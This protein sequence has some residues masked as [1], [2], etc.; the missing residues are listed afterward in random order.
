MKNNM[1]T[2]S[3]QLMKSLNRS[4]ILNII[5]E[6]GPISRA[7]IAKLTKLTPPTVGNLVKELM[8]SEM[9]IETVLGESS[10]GRKPTMLT[11]NS[12]AFH[13]I[14]LDIGSHHL[15]VI[16]TNMEGMLI[17]KEMYPMP[18]VVSN[19]SL[20]DLLKKAIS[21][22]KTEAEITV[23][24]II[25]IGVGMH[26]IVD[27]ENGISVFAPN[28]NLKNIEI[29]KQ[30]EQ[31]FNMLV[32]VD[33]DARAMS[34][35]ELWFGN[36]TGVDSLVC[37]NVGRG[38]GAGIIIDGKLFRG[39]D[40]IGGEIGHMTID[41]NGP[42]CSCGNNG[43][44]QAFASGPAIAAT[45]QKAASVQESKLATFELTE[46]D[47]EAVYQAAVE[48]DQ[49]SQHILRQAGV[50]LGVGITN[51]IHMVNPERII[52]GGGVSNAKEFLLPAINETIAQ[53]GLTGS[54]QKT[55]ILISKFGEDATAIGAIALILREVFM[56]GENG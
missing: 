25:G 13:V 3:F 17:K 23:D 55:E 10:G 18:E 29:K 34:L 5:R 19:E 11:L 43:C 39:H 24:R 12:N 54:V 38:V 37:I 21:A 28:L 15:K 51:L 45:A 6:K 42:K 4:V 46:I 56:T 33:N 27:V 50:Y 31:E 41:L 2:G 16:I 40:N 26:G 52:I 47:G 1:V 20:L 22:I 35:G 48:G 30:L 8:Y 36:G 44:L 53:R 7:D 9:V 32:Q 14:G 49:L